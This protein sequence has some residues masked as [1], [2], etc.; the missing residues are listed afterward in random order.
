MRLFIRALALVVCIAPVLLTC[1]DEDE[2][3]QY[4]PVGGTECES[5]FLAGDLV[6]TEIMANPPSTDSGNEWFE[7]YNATGTRVNL[8]RVVILRGSDE[9]DA[10]ENSFLMPEMW[11]EAG[12]YLVLGDADAET[13]PEHVDFSYGDELGSMGNQGGYLALRC[14]E[15]TIDAVAY[16]DT[17]NGISLGFDGGRT[18]DTVANDELDNW[19][20]STVEYLD[21]AFGSPGAANEPCAPITGETTC[22][23]ADGIRDVIAPEVGD[24]VI[25]EF[26]ANPHAVSDSDGEWIEITATAD[27]DLNGL[28]IGTEVGTAR[29]TLEDSECLYVTTGTQILL[30]RGEESGE[31]GGLDSVDHV[32]TFSLVN[33][34]GAVF[35][36]FGDTTLD[37]ITY[38]STYDGAS[39]AL[40]PDF[41]DPV[42]NDDEAV[43]CEG[44]DVYG[45]GDLGTPG[46]TNTD[47]PLVVPTGQCVDGGSLRDAVAP[48]VGD[49]IITEFM[50][51]P[52]TVSDS[53]GEWF[54]LYVVNAIDLNGLEIGTAVGTVRQTVGGQDCIPIAAGTHVLFAKKSDPLA[55]GGLPTVDYTFGFSLTNRDSG[56]FVGYGGA[57]LDT[58][59]YASVSDGASTSLNPDNYDPTDNDEE[60]N[61]CV[62]TEEIAED[63]DFGTPGA[64][65]TDCPV[66]VPDGS[67]L[68]GET[69]RAIVPPVAGDLVITELMPDPAQVGDTEGEWFEIYVDAAAEVDLNGILVR[70]QSET[71]DTEITAVEC[72]TASP[73]SYVLFAHDDDPLA[74][75]DLPAVQ[76]LFDFSMNNTAGEL[77]VMLGET[78]IDAISYDSVS[79][80]TSI[81]LDSG[82][83]SA[84]AN[85]VAGNWCEGSRTYNDGDFG[86]PGEANSLCAQFVPIGQCVGSGGLRDLAE[87]A[88]GDLIIT[89]IMPNPTGSP[90]SQNHEWFEIYV[91]TNVDLNGVG[92]RREADTDYDVVFDTHICIPATAGTY[93][94]F[95]GSTDSAANAG[96]PDVDY[97]FGFS[98][99]NSNSGLVVSVGGDLIDEATYSSST[100]G[101]SVSL[102]P[103]LSTSTDND[104]ED[105]WCD[106]VAAYPADPAGDNMGTPA[107]AN[108]VCSSVV[109]LEPGECRVGNS[110]E[111]IMPPAAGDLVITEIMADPDGDSRQWFEVYVNAAADVDLN[112]LGLGADPGAYTVSQT[113]ED[114]YCLT[115][116]PE[117]TVLFVRDVVTPPDD[118]LPDAD[119]LFEFDLTSPDDRV[120][121]RVGTEL[122]DQVSY[123]GASDGVPMTLDFY[124]TSAA[125]NDVALNWCNNAATPGDRNEECEPGPDDCRAEDTS[126]RPVVSPVAGDLLITEIMAN[127]GGTE[128]QQEWFEVYVVN[129]VDLRGLEVGRDVGT[130]EFSFDDG[131][132]R[133]VTA[134]SYLLFARTENLGETIGGLTAP[135]HIYDGM[136]LYSAGN[137]FI[138]HD[139][140]VID[141]VVGYTATNWYSV[142]LDKRLIEL[143]WN[144]DASYFC[145]GSHVYG[146]GVG[147]ERN[148]GTPGVENDMCAG[149]SPEGV[150]VDEVSL[151][152]REIEYPEVGDLIITEFLSN[153]NGAESGH[154]HDWFEVYVDAAAAIDLNGLEVGRRDNAE[155]P[156]WDYQYTLEGIEGACLTATPDT[157]LVFAETA[158][159]DDNGGLPGTF[160]ADLALALNINDKG[161]VL[162]YDIEGDEDIIDHITYGSTIEGQS[163]NLDWRLTDEVS[164]DTQS[165]WCSTA[166]TVDNDYDDEAGD[167]NYGTPGDPNGAAVDEPAT[168]CPDA[169]PEGQCWDLTSVE[170]RAPVPPSK[171][172]LF[173]TEVLANADGSSETNYEWIE[174][175]INSDIDL[176]GIEISG[177][178][179]DAVTFEMGTCDD[180]TTDEYLVIAGSD[181]YG[182]PTDDR[183]VGAWNPADGSY[184]LTNGVDAV[185]LRFGTVDL[186]MVEWTSGASDG[187]SRY[188]STTTIAAMATDLAAATTDGERD[189]ILLNNDNVHEGSWADCSGN[190]YSGANSGTPGADNTLCPPP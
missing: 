41:I 42:A 122:I 1:G 32:L 93:L 121:L 104:D 101:A 140:A 175:Y 76:H 64:L 139:S 63:S 115:V 74:N 166:A 83:I 71:G 187:V 90:E 129:T 48:A 181:I 130:V 158:V 165:Y 112:G 24:L 21:D 120:F 95:A 176:N 113:L 182:G 159:A 169:Y 143:G 33:S 105:N 50:P 97:E 163:T 56:L 109:I 79:G 47:C 117:S 100:D 52:K 29:M 107:A 55:N 51:N 61:W 54:E 123:T 28:Q 84:D 102:D 70:S 62:G 3:P 87:P 118:G 22:Q 92:I 86:S 53:D 111:D 44:V 132:C 30:A 190:V 157:W 184:D 57:V 185:Y 94:L 119:F 146:D 173:I 20:L 144:D 4:V 37:Q 7:I 171:G 98:L 162:G 148:H 96:L 155:D 170:W 188:L 40:D 13:V 5:G 77:H 142:T 147:D 19:C 189:G 72:L 12:E 91:A 116:S 60:S 156:N 25:S 99:L 43:W 151:Q 149:V 17:E 73:G 89:E 108:P 125:E 6:F 128:S 172:D 133:Q 137:L 9:A 75:G 186:D 178:G 35:I 26:L 34:S 152:F 110:A 39:T 15:T 103:R 138:G 179:D 150:C 59:S 82:H 114:E 69:I 168:F 80:G 145:D 65:N 45:D 124:R 180:H 2:R 134:G 11:I 66:Q 153:P 174:L 68:D 46:A 131:A 23:E 10:G 135:Y 8:A 78:T 127:P 154:T 167:G 49:V 31:N 27:V 16:A 58:I 38:S 106:G 161:I 183:L 136:T 85:D 18:P 88:P 67:C 126:V 141:S 81:S 164:N 14:G 160:Y 177:T 36:G